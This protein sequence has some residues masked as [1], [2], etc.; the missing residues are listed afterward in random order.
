MSR[1]N[2]FYTRGGRPTRIL[3]TQTRREGSERE[4]QLWVIKLSLHNRDY[5]EQD[6]TAAAAERKQ[7]SILGRRR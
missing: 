6:D 5:N 2:L 4:K 1:V 7:K 3:F